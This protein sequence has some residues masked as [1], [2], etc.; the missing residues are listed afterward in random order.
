MLRRKIDKL[1][2]EWKQKKN[3]KA[4][5]VRGARQVGKT[6]SIRNLGESYDSFIEINFLRNKS[7]KEIFSGDLDV[8]A[9]ILNFSVYLPEARFIKGKTLLFLDEIQECP[10]AITSLKFW[11]EDGRFD[12]IAS[13][14]MLGIDYNRPVSYPVGSI[15]YIDMYALSFE[16]FVWSQE[17]SDTVI[18]TL[19]D[20]LDSVKQV[21]NAINDRMH[22]L[23]RLYIAVGGMPEAVTAFLSDNSFASCYEV[24]SRILND[25]KYDIAHYALPDVKIKAESCYFS[26][27]DQLTKPNHKFQY[28]L[29]EKG[30]NQRKYSS[31]LEWLLGAYLVICCKNVSRM[32]SPL[33]NYSDD[34]NFRLYTSDIGLLTA[35]F[36]YEIKASIVADSFDKKSG[37]V[38]GGLYEALIADILYKNGHNSLYFRKNE[39]ATFELE[40]LLE[41]EEGV[42]P[43]EVKAKNSRS[44][45]LDNALK[46]AEIPY[47]YKLVGG[48]LGKDGKKI[49]LPLYMAMFL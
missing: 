43:L 9:L 25:Y 12:V 41:N 39:Q 14:S 6:T 44:K 42:I 26:L 20:C 37:Y 46:K 24:Q 49:T 27:R 48:N 40:F 31:S 18:G 4:L 17:I 47:G 13:G 33:S 34:G 28:S 22:E 11:V 36:D 8:D 5:L 21:P 29:L 15:E 23:L 32:E 7:F 2:K 10:E 1:L 30:G 19:R 35:M 45:S 3:K 38:R 16:E